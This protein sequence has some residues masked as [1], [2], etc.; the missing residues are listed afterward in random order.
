MGRFDPEKTAAYRLARQHSKAIRELLNG[1]DTR[2]FADVVAQLRRSAVSIPANVLEAYGEWRPGKR[3][4]Y[5]M[6][7]KGSAWESWAHVDS[8]VD[9][10]LIQQSATVKVRDLQ[11]QISAVLIATIR[12]VEAEQDAAEPPPEA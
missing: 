3:L 7:A 11:N 10:G 5:L 2:G 1:A 6:I 8:M 12:N 4:H 9:F